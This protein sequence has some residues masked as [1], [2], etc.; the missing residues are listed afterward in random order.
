MNCNKVVGVDVKKIVV[1]TIGVVA[2]CLFF[3]GTITRLNAQTRTGSGRILI[4]YFSHQS[5]W[6]DIDNLTGAS[7]VVVDG[8]MIGH[9]EHIANTIQRAIGGDLFTIRTVQNYP[10][11]HRQVLDVARQEQSENARPRLAT[12]SPNLQNYDTI[13]LGFPKWWGDMPAI[14]NLPPYSPLLQRV[15][16]FSSDI[17]QKFFP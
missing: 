12:R 9:V 2:I 1:V 13:F 6:D 4:A 15:I 16:I 14:L 3:A 5:Q 11:P 7:R 10:V 17:L 8:I